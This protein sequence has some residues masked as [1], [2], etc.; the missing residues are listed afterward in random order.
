MFKFCTLI[1]N[2]HSLKLA[3]AFEEASAQTHDHIKSVEIFLNRKTV[4]D[5]VEQKQIDSLLMD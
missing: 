5:F 1:R 3:H 2:S 4:H